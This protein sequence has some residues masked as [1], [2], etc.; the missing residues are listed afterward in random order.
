MTILITID[1]LK[2]IPLREEKLYELA[3]KNMEI[4]FEYKFYNMIEIFEEMPIDEEEK[5]RLINRVKRKLCMFLQ[6]KKG[7]GGLQQF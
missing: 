5:R 3:L 1:I 7:F 6:T 4:K 2:M